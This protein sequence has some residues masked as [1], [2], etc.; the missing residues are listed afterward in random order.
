MHYAVREN[1][2]K[3]IEFFLSLNKPSLILE[4]NR[5][6][7][8]PLSLAASLNQQSTVNLFIEKVGHF[9]PCESFNA[10][11]GAAKIKDI[12]YIKYLV[13]KGLS[14]NVRQRNLSIIDFTI[15]NDLFSVFEFFKDSNLIDYDDIALIA[16][17][18]VCGRRKIF[19]LLIKNYNGV[20]AEN[21]LNGFL[22]N[23]MPLDQKNRVQIIQK[24]KKNSSL[25]YVPKKN[26]QSKGINAN[27]NENM[28]DLIWNAFRSKNVIQMRI[29]LE[30]GANPN[31]RNKDGNTLLYESVKEGN[32]QI[33]DL[34]FSFGANPDKRC[35][36]TNR[37]P[38]YL[39]IISD[40]IEII[41]SFIMNG[42]NIYSIDENI[43][44][45]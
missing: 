39:A 35:K 25:K 23:L 13:S 9:R 3:V 8:S 16:L 22:P 38:L 5:K 40:K 2:T 19:D 24:V 20:K 21:L 7:E 36:S 29:L 45:Y 4:Q 12:D 15:E 30:F 6:G 34:L 10:L 33:I 14:V 43:F 37:S 42:A 18:Y 31:A 17:A 11:K 44:I 41:M 27:N 28:N 32:L 1:Q 26:L